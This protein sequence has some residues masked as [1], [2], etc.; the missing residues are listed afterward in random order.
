MFNAYA[1]ILW[2]FLLGGLAITLW[3]WSIIATAR[4][5]LRWPQV[6]GVIER[7]DVLSDEDDLLPMIVFSYLV[8]G[9]QQN[10]KVEFPAGTMPTPELAASYVERYPLGSRVRVFY[11]PMNIQQSTLAPGMGQGDWMIFALG[12]MATIVAIMSLVMSD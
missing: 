5:T 7:S 3:G 2:L 11:N 12:V 10:G 4:Q 9:Q 1:V 6:D 8:N